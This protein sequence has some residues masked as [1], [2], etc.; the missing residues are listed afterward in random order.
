MSG[1]LS[2]VILSSADS[3]TFKVIAGEHRVAAARDSGLTEIYAV[4]VEGFSEIQ[5]ELARIDENLLHR[6]LGP[7]AEAKALARRKEIFES[8]SPE[9]RRGGDRRS[10]R[11]K[12]QVGRLKG[13]AAITAEATG[14]SVKSISRSVAR[15]RKVSSAIL[16]QISNTTLDNGRFL[17]DLTR[18]PPEAQPG[19]VINEIEERN[20]KSE[21]DDRVAVDLRRLRSAWASACVEAQDMFRAEITSKSNEVSK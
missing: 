14:R 2:A 3:K 10:A 9:T 18:M 17:D 20:N 5:L 6:R 8:L 16:D 11:S 21:M 4:V 1:F 12:A 13:F 15:G 19:A 7:A